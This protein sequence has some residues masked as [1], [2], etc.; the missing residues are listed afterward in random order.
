MVGEAF[1]A[2]GASSGGRT[3]GLSPHPDLP[4]GVM[5]SR[6]H[7]SF[8]RSLFARRRLRRRHVFFAMFVRSFVILSQDSVRG[9][10]QDIAQRR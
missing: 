7:L 6:V 2:R 3:F 5:R 9:E 1:G 10:R 8:V 4:Y